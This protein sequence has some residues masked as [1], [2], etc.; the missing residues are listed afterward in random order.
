M[1]KDDFLKILL[2]E[3]FVCEK[4]GQYPSVVCDAKDVK[5]TAKRVRAIAKDKGYTSSFAVR[6][7]REGMEL[8]SN[9]EPIPMQ[10]ITEEVSA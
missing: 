8:I 7:A 10:P 6:S 5:T 1:T 4:G 2:A 3:G 9:K